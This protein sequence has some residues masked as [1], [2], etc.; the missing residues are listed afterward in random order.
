MAI[1]RISTYGLFQTTF[2]NISKVD[3][4]LSNL[5]NQLSSGFKSS[6][7]DGI[8]ANAQQFLQLD[9]KLSRTDHYINNN[10]IINVRVNSTNNVLS[11]VISTANELKNLILQRRNASNDVGVFQTQINGIWQTLTGQ[12]NTTIDGRY[13]F[14]G[15]RTD[16]KAVDD[17]HFPQIT[18][19]DTNGTDYYQGDDQDLS[20]KVSDNI[21]MTYNVRANDDGIQKIFAGLA[22]A[23]EG[24]SGDNDAKLAQ[25][26]DLVNDGIKG[27]I[28]AQAKVNA[29]V[30]QLNDVG[31]NLTSLQTYWKGIKEEIGNTDLVTAST[32]VAVNQSI[33]QAT[34]QTF[35]RITS[36]RL[37]DF[38]S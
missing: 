36:L 24:D 35:A 21:S 22:L 13:I 26:F 9:D 14:S 16:T 2:S 8:S 11:Q 37:S 32:Q 29:N 38:L 1:D 17:E 10:S 4:D 5:Q 20:V 19:A 25:A 7:F 31:N 18:N 12:L 28:T 27:V 3:G 33:L 30:V 34:F 15:G 6:T 23:S